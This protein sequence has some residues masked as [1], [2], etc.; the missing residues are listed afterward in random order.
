MTTTVLGKVLTDHGVTQASL[1]RMLGVS[2]VAIHLWVTGKEAIPGFRAEEVA[3]YLDLDPNDAEALRSEATVGQ[4]RAA[5]EPRTFL[6]WLLRFDGVSEHLGRSYGD[7][8][9]RLAALTD[10]PVATVT[11]WLSGDL[12]IPTDRAATLNL[13]AWPSLSVVPFYDAHE[14]GVN[15]GEAAAVDRA[16]SDYIFETEDMT[17]SGVSK[18]LQ[19]AAA[20]WGADPTAVVTSPPIS[21]GE[22]PD[23]YLEK[24]AEFAAMKGVS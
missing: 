10:V 18:Y 14:V 11:R 13:S 15:L 2:H 22:Y 23:F 1:A 17:W 19:A 3:H 20:K 21:I 16:L 5:A 7:R 6:D 12:R 4:V 8:V 24:A 9:L